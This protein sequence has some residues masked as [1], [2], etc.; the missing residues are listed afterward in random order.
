MLEY[1]KLLNYLETTMNIKDFKI[2]GNLTYGDFP[3]IEYTYD[4]IVIQDTYGLRQLQEKNIPITT[5]VDIG[6]NL[7]IFSAFARTLFPQ[8][9]IVCLEA[10]NDT[11]LSLKENLQSYNVETYNMAFG[12]GSTLFFNKC[13]DHSGANQ[14]RKIK[15]DSHNPEINIISKTLQDI[16][17]DLKIEQPYI[18]KMDIEGSEMFLYDNPMCYDILRNCQY[19]TMEYH[20]VN[21]LGY[22]VDKRKWDEWL[23]TVF[24]DFTIEGLGGNATGA[25]Y[26]I[27]KK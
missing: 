8:A 11:Y 25:T 5:I 12:D 3:L 7:G 4:E 23:L 19:F 2:I 16:F 17:S 22:I 14:F 24:V 15:S 13:Q 10:L 27:I 6:G 1:K 20:N 26:K 9:R 21:M 18:I